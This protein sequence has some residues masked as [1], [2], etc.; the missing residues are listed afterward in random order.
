MAGTFTVYHWPMRPTK[1]KRLNYSIDTKNIQ[2]KYESP[3]DK[4]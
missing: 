2:S 1:A 4:G 3:N